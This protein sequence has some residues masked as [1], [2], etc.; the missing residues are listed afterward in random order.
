[1]II[2]SNHEDRLA[3]G[4]EDQFVARYE[5]LSSC[6]ICRLLSGISVVL[7]LMLDFIA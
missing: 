7:A 1:M 5:V 4:D 2:T 3:K 6:P